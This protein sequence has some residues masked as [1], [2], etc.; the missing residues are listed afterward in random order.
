MGLRVE[1]RVHDIGSKK[2]RGCIMGFPGFEQYIIGCVCV[3]VGGGGG[4]GGV[5]SDKGRGKGHN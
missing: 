2:R 5:C 1:K 3:C 4:G